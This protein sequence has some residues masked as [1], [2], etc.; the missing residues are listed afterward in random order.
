MEIKINIFNNNPDM[1]KKNK[2]QINLDI[3]HDVNNNSN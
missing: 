1:F 3:D 2:S